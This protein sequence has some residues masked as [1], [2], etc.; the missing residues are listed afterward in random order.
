M[1]A[2][3]INFRQYGAST[4]IW[5]A[6][7]AAAGAVPYA[8][9]Y[10]AGE[11]KISKDGGAFANTTNL[12]TYLS[13]GVYNVVL[14]AVEMQ[15]T[16]INLWFYTA[17]AQAAYVQID[18]KL[19]VSQIFIGA[20]TLPTSNIGLEV[21]GGGGGGEAVKL[22]PTLADN[23]G[24]TI[25]GA[26]TG[27]GVLI[28]G[29]ATGIGLAIDAGAFGATGMQVN[30]VAGNN[31]A[32]SLLGAGTGSGLAILGGASG[33]GLSVESSGATAVQFQ[34]TAGNNTGLSLI[35]SGTGAGL[36]ATGGATN[37]PG[38]V[39]IGQ[40]TGVGF[41]GQSGSSQPT[42]FFSETIEDIT[43][44][45]TPGA[46]T[47]RQAIAALT[48]RMYNLVTQTTTQQKI[49]SSDS[50]TVKA[51]AAVSDDGTTQTKGRAT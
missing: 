40:G 37:A 18:T 15:A 30:S 14:T 33:L 2:K 4:S 45:P 32:V 50:V 41:N 11:S 28:T 7:V 48:A 19:I 6:A 31:N 5:F 35:G 42:N 3:D 27:A 47:L 22:W 9:G 21:R 25:I 29:G 16:N 39:G 51:I 43:G 1:A 12:P 38:I 36:Q 17:A 24:M 23:N 44:V 26:G 20:D 46:T 13:G 49:Y 8:A 10:A 34:A